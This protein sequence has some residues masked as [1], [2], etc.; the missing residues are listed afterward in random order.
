MQWEYQARPP[1]LPDGMAFPL[2]EEALRA[3]QDP[4]PIHEALFSKYAAELTPW[5]CFPSLCP[6]FDAE[7]CDLVEVLLSGYGLARM[8]S[9]CYQTGLEAVVLVQ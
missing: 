4:L 2:S 5:G 1:G 6:P 8:S 9:I 3:L 7:H